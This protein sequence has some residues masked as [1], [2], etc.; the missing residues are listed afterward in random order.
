MQIKK[1]S[2]ISDQELKTYTGPI[3][4]NAIP[5]ARSAGIYYYNN[6]KLHREDGPAVEYYDGEKRWFYQDRHIRV[7]SQ[8]EFEAW[9]KVSAFE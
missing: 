3:I 1:R 2:E 4:Y 7:N 5:Y 8:E 9:L 6:G